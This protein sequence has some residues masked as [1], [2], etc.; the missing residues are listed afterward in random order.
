VAKYQC[1]GFRTNQ[2]WRLIPPG[3]VRVQ[4]L[5]TRLLRK[6]LVGLAFDSMVV[7]VAPVSLAA[8]P[9]AFVTR[10]ALNPPLCEKIHDTL[11]YSTCANSN[12][13]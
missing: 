9:E 4:W 12:T 2:Y 5:V 3:V 6:T 7:G 11:R 13:H 1:L 8:G 10:G